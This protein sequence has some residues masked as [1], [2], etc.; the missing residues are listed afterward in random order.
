[1]KNIQVRFCCK[2]GERII[3]YTEYTRNVTSGLD[4]E[5]EVIYKGV[6]YKIVR[7]SEGTFD[8]LFKDY[9]LLKILY[10]TLESQLQHLISTIND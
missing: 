1:M 2:I 3:D 8:T 5:Q 9:P 10:S 7:T 6:R 4:V